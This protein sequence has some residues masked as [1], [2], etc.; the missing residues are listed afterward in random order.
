[1]KLPGLLLLA[2]VSVAACSPAAESA[3]DLVEEYDHDKLAALYYEADTVITRNDSVLVVNSQ[4]DTTIVDTGIFTYLQY[5]YALNTPA[6]LVRPIRQARQA[7]SNGDAARARRHYQDAIRFYQAEW[8]QQKTGFENGGFSDLND[9]YAAQVNVA[10]L[11]SYAFEKLGRLPEA[12][13]ALAPF[14]AN[15]EAEKTR[16]QLRY[17]RLCIRHHG[18]AATRRALDAS[19][20]SVHRRGSE[21]APEAYWWCVVVFGANLGVAD[22][23]TEALSAEQAQQLV[24][25]QPYY[26]LVK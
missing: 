6:G 26:T 1:M 12:L 19:G 18:K 17:I 7:E 16:I 21:D 14:L 20:P 15:V 22:F 8:L 10:L 3:P 9:Y 11:A 13:A 23:N 4:M 24:E 2:A 5:D 25:K